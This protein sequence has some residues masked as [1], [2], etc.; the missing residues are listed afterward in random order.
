MLFADFIFVLGGGYSKK[1]SELCLEL[2]GDVSL[3]D[4]F[5]FCEMDTTTD[6]L[7]LALTH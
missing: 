1:M 3:S 2:L 7:N 5:F 6:F 4:F